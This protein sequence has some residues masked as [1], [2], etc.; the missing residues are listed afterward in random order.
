M[1]SEKLNEMLVAKTVIEHLEQ[2][3]YELKDDPSIWKDWEAY[4]NT[5]LANPAF[6]KSWQQSQFQFKNNFRTYVNSRLD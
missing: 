6:R 2:M 4:F 1:H 5:Y 3:F